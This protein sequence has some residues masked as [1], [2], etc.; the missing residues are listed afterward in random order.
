MVKIDP[1][2]CDDCPVMQL[3]LIL[4]ARNHPDDDDDD[5][6]DDDDDDDDGGDIVHDDVDVK[7]LNALDGR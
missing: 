1:L 4:P 7:H 3:Q 2:S 5:G 6:D